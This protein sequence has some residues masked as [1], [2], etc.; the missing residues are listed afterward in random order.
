METPNCTCPY[1]NGDI[2]EFVH[3]QI[4]LY[5]RRLNAKR[6]NAAV[7]NNADLKRKRS[8]HGEKQLKKWHAENPD[9]AKESI[10]RARA[11]RTPETFARQSESI[12]QTIIRK[13]VVF[14]ELLAKEKESSSDISPE[15]LMEL[16]RRAAAIVRAE[17]KS[18]K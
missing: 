16:S 5:V 18:K 3:E 8:E 6:M 4:I 9:K 15:R 14:A 1:C 13:N 10:A 17:K 7:K 11:M 2:S 12:K